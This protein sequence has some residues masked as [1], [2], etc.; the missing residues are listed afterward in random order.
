MHKAANFNSV[1]CICKFVA[2][3]G[4]AGST[5]GSLL[6]MTHRSLPKALRKFNCDVELGGKTTPLRIHTA[7][8]RLIKSTLIRII[9]SKFNPMVMVVCQDMA[10]CHPDTRYQGI[11]A[12]V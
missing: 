10:V 5:F 2:S 4:Q 12:E 8:Q 6:C 9:G 11:H 1:K 7:S 3:I